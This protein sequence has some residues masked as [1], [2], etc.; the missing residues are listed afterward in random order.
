MFPI[1]LPFKKDSLN[2]KVSIAL[3]TDII[4]TLFIAVLNLIAVYHIAGTLSQLEVLH[5]YRACRHFS[6][7]KNVL[8]KIGTIDLLSVE[9]FHEHAKFS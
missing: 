3:K 8:P 7:L 5:S 4:G 6:P 9:Q 2:L 1:D